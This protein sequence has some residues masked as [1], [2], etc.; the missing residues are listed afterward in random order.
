MTES[1]DTSPG[2][3]SGRAPDFE[4]RVIGPNYEGF[5]VVDS[6]VDA[7]SSGG[8]RITDDLAV[9][10]VRALAREMTHKYSLFHLPR[11]GAK[12]GLRLSSALEG[13]ARLA[14]LEDFGRRVAPILRNGI[15]NPGMDMNCG[16]DQ[17][18]AIYRGA[19][20]GLGGMT[21]TSLY[22]A[23]TVHHSLRAVADRMAGTERPLTLAVE[24]F[25][26][27]ARHLARRLDPTEFRIV[28]L[29]TIEGGVRNVEGFDLDE[30]VRSK[31]EHGD[32][33]V[34]ELSGET[35]A[36]AEVLTTEADIVLP[37]SRTWVISREIAERMRTRAVVPI[38]NVPFA[39]GT[40]D[41]L[42][43]RGLLLLPGFVSNVGGVLASSLHDL[44]IDDDEVE[45]LTE[46]WYRPVVDGLLRLAE[47][48]EQPA[49]QVAEALAG[50]HAS[51][52]P[53][54]RTRSLVRRVHERLIRPRLPRSWRARAAR[55]DFVAR[56]RMILHE[57]GQGE[58]RG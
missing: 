1:S 38:S 48:Q 31:E 51:S 34:H 6:I 4:L 36:P 9:D 7:R 49:S 18:R 57:I 24:G 23:L 25:G 56:S 35:I 37:S 17:L 58:R 20:I 21:D 46:A 2:P 30:L 26:S 11:G 40:V 47:L 10:E 28:A 53:A 33:L 16:P 39:E 50:R 15:Y 13:P 55:E 19:G 52:R 41:L 43:E 27:V 44:G 14:A 3:S 5:V 22:T 45:S 54:F 12:A 32:R 42:H 29:A 8:V